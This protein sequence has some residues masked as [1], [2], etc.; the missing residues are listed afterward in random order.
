MR[1]SQ[2]ETGLP[3]LPVSFTDFRPEQF[4]EPQPAVKI[5]KEI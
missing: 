4:S 3:P 1:S 2:K 5:A